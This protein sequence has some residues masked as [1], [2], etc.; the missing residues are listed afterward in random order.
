MTQICLEKIT[1]T[2]PVKKILTLLELEDSLASSLH[3]EQSY[4]SS[5][6]G[7]RFKLGRVLIC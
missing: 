7:T 4:P 1:V 2:Q 5:H 6:D 3:S